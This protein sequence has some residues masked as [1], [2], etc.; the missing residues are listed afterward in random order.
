M[1]HNKES[2]PCIIGSVLGMFGAL[3]YS[4][5][6]LWIPSIRNFPRKLILFLSIYDFLAGASYILPGHVNSSFCKFQ[7]LLIA[8][9]ITSPS[10]WCFVI[11]IIS[12]RRLNGVDYSTAKKHL[13]LIHLGMHVISITLALFFF[14]LSKA[15]VRNTHWCWITE[16][17]LEVIVYTTYWA[18]LVGCLAIYIIIMVMIEKRRRKGEAFE[19]SIRR[20]QIK[21]FFIPILYIFTAFWS[22]WKRLREMIEHKPRDE[23]WLDITQAL[24]LPTEGFWD[25]ILFIVFDR[26]I[27]RAIREK[28]RNNRCC[29]NSIEMSKNDL[30]TGLLLSGDDF[31]DLD[32][33]KKDPITQ[34]LNEQNFDQLKKSNP[35]NIEQPKKPK[36]KYTKK[37][38][39]KHSDSD[40]VSSCDDIIE[41]HQITHDDL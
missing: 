15:E 9:F 4:F 2:I 18:L 31:Y 27:R 7:T 13:K 30:Q 17:H 36:K 8:Y 25:F 6:Y 39:K 38:K 21:M 3:V 29:S 19:S 5:V 33:E 26:E 24:F 40:S 10:Y 16:I 32:S 11:S 12:L 35:K 1:I 23:D 34:E 22:S 37:S 14:F 41:P 20:F 28:F